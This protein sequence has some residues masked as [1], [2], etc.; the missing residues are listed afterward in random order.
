MGEVTSSSWPGD[1]HEMMP[2]RR[3]FA[4]RQLLL[5]ILTWSRSI[6]DNNISSSCSMISAL[7]QAGGSTCPFPQ[8]V[9]G[10]THHTRTPCSRLQ[11]S[12]QTA[13]RSSH[14]RS[15]KAFTTNPP[16][17]LQDFKVVHPVRPSSSQ[18][19]ISSHCRETST[20]GTSLPKATP[21]ASH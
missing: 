10:S 21:P 14:R 4:A 20:R 9:L 15:N 2:E 6:G 13:L 5:D 17:L 3:P 1:H 18:N 16:R 11:H 12:S 7:S 8:F 19:S